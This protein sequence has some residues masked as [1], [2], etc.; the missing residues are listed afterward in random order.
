M[1]VF[2]V[3]KSSGFVGEVKQGEDS[4]P[5]AMEVSGDKTSQ[6]EGRGPLHQRRSKQGGASP[7]VLKSFP[8]QGKAIVFS[9]QFLMRVSW[10]D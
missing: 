3:A 7:L 2:S 8:T 1:P 10:L 9:M 6:Q 4:K 5:E